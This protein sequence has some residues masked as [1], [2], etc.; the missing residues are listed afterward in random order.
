MG[1][2]DDRKQMRQTDWW[3]GENV[4]SFEQRCKDKYNS[5]ANQINRKRNEKRERGFVRVKK[6]KVQENENRQKRKRAK[7]KGEKTY[8][9]KKFEKDG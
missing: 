1:E 8:C 3:P 7:E 9:E 2:E 5:S 6:D 4:L